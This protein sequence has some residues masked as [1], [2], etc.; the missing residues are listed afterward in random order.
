MPKQK[1]MASS[2]ALPFYILHF[3]TA[4]VSQRGC[5]HFGTLHYSIHTVIYFSKTYLSPQTSNS[6]QTEITVAYN[7]HRTNTALNRVSNFILK[8]W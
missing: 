3:H 6:L 7:P 4:S 1:T 8:L 5:Y 2:Q